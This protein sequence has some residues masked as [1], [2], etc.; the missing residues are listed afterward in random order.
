MTLKNRLWNEYKISCHDAQWHKQ[1]AVL[2]FH[3]L[4]DPA[5]RAAKIADKTKC[6]VIHL[7][8]SKVIIEGF[9]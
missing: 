6:D 3:D 9:V 1:G 2:T 4:T 5:E 8:D 7:S